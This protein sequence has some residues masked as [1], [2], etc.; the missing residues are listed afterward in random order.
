MSRVLTTLT[1]L[2]CLFA[3]STQASMDHY[4]ASKVT[5]HVYVIH[6]PVETPNP[7]NR[8]F[9]N[10]PAFIVA[11]KGVIVVDPGSS[12]ETGTMVLRNIKAV[13]DK[14]VTH[15]FNTHVHGDHWLANDIILKS[16]PDAIIYADPRMIKKA[17]GGAAQEWLDMLEDLTAGATRG[18]KIAYP[19]SR[20]Q[21]GQTLNIHNLNFRIHSVGIAHSDTD[22]MIEL[23]DDSIMFTGD[24]VAYQRIL[25]LD[26][27][28]F[29]D[30]IAACEKAISLGLKYYVPGHG[31]SGS[32]D[33][34]K[35]QKQYLET[36]Y[37][38]A[39]RYYEDGLSDFEMKPR[40]V[41]ALSE[42]KNWFGFD[43]QI[44]RHISLAVL[45]IEQSEFE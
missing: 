34:V 45:E 21:D 36:L 5:Q 29:K 11:D 37:R 25:R 14:P 18:T 30:N 40:V 12:H 16:Y 7:E 23:V 4:Q 24:N 32:V 42:F 35:Q 17:R 43:H 33:L 13:T 15:I 44:G 19:N 31:P 20:A 39:S 10:N 3:A 8:G 41:E 1:G 28:N 2:M 38:E 9:M 22:I 6:G 26:D 27:G